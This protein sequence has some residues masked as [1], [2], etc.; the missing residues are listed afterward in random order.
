M[1]YLLTK[2]FI[3]EAAVA[4]RRIVKFGGGDTAVEAATG[5][6]D[7]LIG[8]AAELGAAADGRIDV[9]LAGIA[10]VEAGGA[11]AR[12]DPITADA[13]GK[14]VAATRH[15]HTENAAAAYTQDADTGIGSVVRT[16]GV[17]LQG[18]SAAGDLIRVLIQ[19]GLA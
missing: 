4:K 2:N 1:D 5:S 19:P 8:I 18:A 16:I 3:A 7:A 14:A 17:A 6:G 9:H 10:E 13:D 12:G 11:I 15:T